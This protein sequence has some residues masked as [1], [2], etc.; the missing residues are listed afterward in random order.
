MKEAIGRVLL[1]STRS[2]KTDF[3]N[4]VAPGYWVLSLEPERL[5]ASWAFRETTMDDSLG[6]GR[7]PFHLSRNSVLHLP[8]PP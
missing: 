1:T 8:I 5:D 6:L 3:G 2:I 4:L 7:R